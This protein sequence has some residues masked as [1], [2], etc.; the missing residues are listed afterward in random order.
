M[1]IRHRIGAVQDYI[2]RLEK[3]PATPSKLTSVS[4]FDDLYI[5]PMQLAN[6]RLEAYKG[7]NVISRKIDADLLELL[8]KRFKT[9]R[10]TLVEHSRP[11]TNWLNCLVFLHFLG[12]GLIH[13]I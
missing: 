3:V 1:E 4:T 8:T 13:F 6:M 11:G 7:D 5:D 12:M 10:R 2:E 9:T